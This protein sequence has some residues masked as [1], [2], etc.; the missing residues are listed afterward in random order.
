MARRTTFRMLRFAVS[1]AAI[2]M[3]TGLSLGLAKRDPAFGTSCAFFIFIIGFA[4]EIVVTP[5]RSSGQD[6]WWLFYLIRRQFRP[7]RTALPRAIPEIQSSP[8]SAPDSTPV[9]AT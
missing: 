7:V 9:P 2:S 5:P 1:W 6:Q 4:L 3:L 8:E